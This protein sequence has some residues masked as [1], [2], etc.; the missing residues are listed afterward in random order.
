MLNPH[1]PRPLT[2]IFKVT[3]SSRGRA[4]ETT[5]LTVLVGAF[6]DAPIFRVG[7]CRAL[8]PQATR[9]GQ[10]PEDGDIV[11]TETRQSYLMTRLEV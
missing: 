8:H 11:E 4:V 7:C 9:M 10:N 3:L 2:Y 1:P 5:V 6:K